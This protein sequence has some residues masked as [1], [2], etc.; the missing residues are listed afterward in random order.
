MTDAREIIAGT[1]RASWSRIIGG[2][3]VWADSL[4]KALI[5]SG[6]VITKRESIGLDVRNCG[7][8][9]DSDITVT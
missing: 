5:A 3:E 2:E 6:Y 8:A 9:V 7:K 1:F 4:I